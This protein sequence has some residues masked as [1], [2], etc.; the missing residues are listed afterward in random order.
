MGAVAGLN[1]IDSTESSIDFV[2]MEAMPSQRIIHFKWHV[3]AEAQ[4]AFF[5]IEKSTDQIIWRSISK[6]KSIEN[7]QAAHTY[8]VS[9]INFAEGEHEFFRIKR[10]DQSGNETVLDV[11]EVNQ[12]VLTNFKMI[13]NSKKTK[14]HQF[15]MSFHSLKSTKGTMRVINSEGEIVYD[16]IVTLNEGY[17][18]LPLN[19]SGFAVDN[20]VVIVRDNSGNRLSQHFTR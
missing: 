18:R 19:A 12:P 4:G 11:V 15:V 10:I 5:E 9:E 3:K 6:T 16:R 1:D 20:Y 8:M 7:H 14:R 13:P 17:N 2:N